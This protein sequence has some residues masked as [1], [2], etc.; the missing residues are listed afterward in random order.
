MKIIS[1]QQTAELSTSVVNS[2]L[3]R[4]IDLINKNIKPPTPV[5]VSE[6]IIRAMYIISDSV[7]SY[8]GQFD[9]ADLP[10]MAKLFIDSPVLIGHDKSGL[11]IARNFWAET[12]EKN[13]R[14]W[15]KTYFY[16]LKKAEGAEKLRL[17]IDSGIYKECSVSFTY[18]FPEC[19]A[20]GKDIRNCGHQVSKDISFYYREVD[21]ILE[22]SLVYRGSIP[23]TMLTNQ[24]AFGKNHSSSA[25]FS[26]GKES[27]KCYTFT[28][29]HHIVNSPVI[30]QNIEGFRACLNGG[31]F[32]LVRKK[33]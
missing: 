11:P 21:K 26:N 30:S 23:D 9:R 4:Y 15:I 29:A 14:L 16:W 32:L 22:T 25:A 20:C 28:P 2:N 12:V 33:G 10:S 1:T 17:N 8:G 18:G 24:L 27:S 7:N 13:D 5:T 31:N 6:V 19:S 3:Q